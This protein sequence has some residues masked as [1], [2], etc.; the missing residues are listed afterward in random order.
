MIMGARSDRY[1]RQ[2]SNARLLDSGILALLYCIKYD[3]RNFDI[4]DEVEALGFEPRHIL[5][6]LF[7]ASHLIEFAAI[8]FNHAV[9]FIFLD[10][11]LCSKVIPKGADFS[12]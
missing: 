1:L 11:S 5:I 4:I 9:G 12:V 8:V 6:L 10:A 2:R 7:V 3:F